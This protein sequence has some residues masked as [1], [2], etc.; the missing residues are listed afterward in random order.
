MVRQAIQHGVKGCDFVII[1]ES[2]KCLVVE[3]KLLLDHV[4]VD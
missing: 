4:K 2:S 1:P 3:E